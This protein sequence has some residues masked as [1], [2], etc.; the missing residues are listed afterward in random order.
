MPR[1]PV[2]TP[3]AGVAL[4]SIGGW[5]ARRWMAVVLGGAAVGLLAGIPTG[6]LPSPLYTRMTPVLWWNYPVWVL[7]MVLGGLAIA[8]YIRTPDTDDRGRVGGVAG[9]GILSTLAI[10]CPVCNKLVVAA[11]G[12]SGALSVWAPL[13]PL[14][15]VAGLGLLAYALLRRLRGEIYCPT[16][17]PLAAAFE[18]SQSNR[19]PR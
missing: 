9:G 18:P 5:P 8:T 15:A 4:R 14:L 11:I 6:V 12:T 7:T 3:P 13:Q 17:L 19:P 1:S 10:G 2:P 16:T